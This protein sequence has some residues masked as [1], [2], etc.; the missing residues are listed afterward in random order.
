MN[1]IFYKKIIDTTNSEYFLIDT[2]EP[3]IANFG[4]T[5][6]TSHNLD[7]IIAG[8]ELGKTKP[9]EEAFEWANED[10]YLIS[11]ENGLFLIDLLAQRA[12]E[13]DSEKI[14][15]QITHD[16]FITFIEDFK[17]FVEENS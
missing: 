12:G 3:V 10:V 9:K 5:N 14:G 13:T 4:D 16:E 8:V 7:E 11:N 6:W 15:L 17:T 1:Y 2:E